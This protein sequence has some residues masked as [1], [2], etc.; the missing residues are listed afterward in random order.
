MA[1]VGEPVPLLL[2]LEL[3]KLPLRNELMGEGEEGLLEEGAARVKF[4]LAEL[5][6]VVSLLTVL[7]WNPPVVAVDDPV[8]EPPT[9]VPVVP[10]G[11]LVVLVVLPNMASRGVMIEVT[12]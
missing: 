6:P 8:V 5:K 2:L 4:E 10:A 11:L 3:P 9:P 1:E 12:R 7:R